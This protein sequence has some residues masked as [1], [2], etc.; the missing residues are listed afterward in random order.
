MRRVIGIIASGLFLAAGAVGADSGPDTA[1]KEK[2]AVAS[3]EKWLALVDGGQYAESWKAA[4][5]YFRN[6]VRSEQFAESMQGLR[7]PLG[8]VVDRKV[9]SQAY[10]TS[11]PGAPDGEYVVIQ[12]ATAFENKKTAVETITPLLEK[13]GQWRVSGYYIR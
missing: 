10:T 8:K 4:A 6:A 9:K 13:D 12:F 2:A 11:L 7:Q 5:A 1:A 3:A